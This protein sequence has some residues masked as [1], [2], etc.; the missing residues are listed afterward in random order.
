MHCHSLGKL[1]YK[2]YDMYIEL[3]EIASN[4][5]EREMQI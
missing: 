4:I 1:R 2:N 3:Y 5:V